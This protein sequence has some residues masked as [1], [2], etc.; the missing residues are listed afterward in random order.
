MSH[1]VVQQ[2]ASCAQTQVLIAFLE[3]PTP[4]WTVQQSPTPVTGPQMPLAQELLQHCALVVQAIPSA[5]HTGSE[6]QTPSRQDLPLQ[7]SALVPQPPPRATQGPQIV[8][9][10]MLPA[11]QSLLSVHEPPAS[12]QPPQMPLPQALPPQQSAEELQASPTGRQAAHMPPTQNF[13]PQHWK[14]SV[15]APPTGEQHWLSWQVPPLQHAL[16]PGPQS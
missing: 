2:Y 14:A 15:Q 10:Q 13:W 16:L 11:Q 3:Q 12:A 4:R 7:Q 5:A 9:K 1:S 6:A 8:V